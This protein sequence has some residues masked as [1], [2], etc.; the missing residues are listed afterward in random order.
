M[1]SLIH[2]YWQA[3]LAQAIVVGLGA[4]CLFVPSVAIIS[5]YFT[6][7]I[8]T[9]IGVAA[10]GSSLGGVIY[11]IMFYKLVP[12]VGFPWAVRIL[13]FMALG[14]LAIPCIVMKMRVKPPAKRKLF[15]IEA[16][17]EVP[18]TL[19]CIGSI[20][21]F[22]GLYVIFFYISYYGYASGLTNESLSFYLIPILNA[23]STFGRLLPNIVADKVGPLNLMGPSAVISSV[24]TYSAIATNSSAGVVLVAAFYGFC[25]GTFVSL[26]PSIVVKLTPVNKRYTIGTR[27]GMY[28]TCG[29]IGALVGGPVAGI[30]LTS[31]NHFSRMFIFGGSLL[32][33]GAVFFGFTRMF[34]ANWKLAVQ[35]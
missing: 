17:K 15:S 31:E 29:S 22:M 20:A 4:G 30:I 23:A 11:P 34:A 14:L 18:Y 2:E 24:I 26:P 33:A 21:G 10:T 5:T 3:V 13:G 9:A 16:F 35:I 7:R 12:E 1:L 28:F 27:L 8:S 6:T 19:F 25:S 32:M